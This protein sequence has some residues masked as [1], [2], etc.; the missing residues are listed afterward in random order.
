MA[1]VGICINSLRRT[2]RATQPWNWVVLGP[3]GP[4]TDLIE[5][6][7]WNQGADGNWVQPQ[8]QFLNPSTQEFGPNVADVPGNPNSQMFPLNSH[9]FCKESQAGAI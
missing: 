7:V 3:L 6:G 8:S 4:S 1:S 2:S 9:L 5:L